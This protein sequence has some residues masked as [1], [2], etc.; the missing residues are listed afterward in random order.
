MSTES[1][2]AP[3][4][5]KATDKWAPLDA[6]F[7]LAVPDFF[8][9]HYAELDLTPGQA[10]F[11]L[12]LLRHKRHGQDLSRNMHCLA[13]EMGLSYSQ[14]RNYVRHLEAKGYLSR[15]LRRGKPS[16]FDLLPLCRTLEALRKEIEARQK[17]RVRR[18]GGHAGG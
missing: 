11:V 16:V 9:D 5:R 14:I 2:Q 3:A 12:H 10:M 6:R 18:F 17:E 13:A 8:L 15:T 4:P 7:W 1:T